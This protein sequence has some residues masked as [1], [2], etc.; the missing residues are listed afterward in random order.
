LAAN[1]ANLDRENGALPLSTK[2]RI[3][4]ERV[5]VVRANPICVVVREEGTSAPASIH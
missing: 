5:P 2:V 4:G 1:L 3:F